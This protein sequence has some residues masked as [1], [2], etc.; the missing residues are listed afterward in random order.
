MPKQ[1]NLSSIPVSPEAPKKSRAPRK[2]A[3]AANPKQDSSASKEISSPSPKTSASNAT[4]TKLNKQERNYLAQFIVRKYVLP[5][6]IVWA[7]DMVI[8]YKLTDRHPDLEFWRLLRVRHQLNSLVILW[9]QKSREKL[10]REFADYE[11]RLAIQRKVVLAKPSK[12][13][14]IGNDKCGEDCIQTDSRAK[15]VREFCKKYGT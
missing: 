4:S 9:S 5:E 14:I 10:T 8:S 11:R 2:R 1:K 13:F 12:T 7:R 15:S 6:K 3:A